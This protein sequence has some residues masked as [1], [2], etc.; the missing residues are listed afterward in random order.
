MVKIDFKLT[1]DLKEKYIKLLC[2]KKFGRGKNSK[3]VIDKFEEHKKLFDGYTFKDIIFIRPESMRGLIENIEA[4]N[5]NIN[6]LKKL[7]KYD[8]KFQ[9][10][11]AKFFE[12]YLNP[13][14]CYYCNIDY[15]NV[16]G[17]KSRRNKFTLDHFIDKG[18]HPYLALSIFNLI[19]SCYICNSKLKG[20][21]PFYE[22]NELENSNPHLKDFNFD[23]RVKFKLFLSKNCR[24]FNIKS[25]NDIEIE[26]KEEYSNN[27][28]KYIE[29]FKLNERYKAHKDIVFEMIENAQLY[30]E[31]RL[32]ELEKLTGVPYQQIKRDI[33]KLIDDE[34]DLSKEPFSKLKRD[35]AYEL[36]LI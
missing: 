25:K 21:I 32:K 31:S 11:I 16:Y 18:R 12:E 24:D 14:T 28:E 13:T 4:K 2:S 15:I 20:S 23:E 6:E 10:I 5:P 22:N 26:L 7:F 29:V 3:T 27:Y 1:E 35:I 19:P 36:G 30:P 8:G 33:F 17:Q 34:V 9:P